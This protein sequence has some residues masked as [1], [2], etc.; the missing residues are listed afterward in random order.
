MQKM[1]SKENIN[2]MILIT[3]KIKMKLKKN[4]Y[5]PHFLL[6]ILFTFTHDRKHFIDSQLYLGVDY[7]LSG[8]S[9]TYF[10]FV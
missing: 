7:T 4:I 9:F 1:C 10:V 2:I 8:K 6:F 3:G 5:I